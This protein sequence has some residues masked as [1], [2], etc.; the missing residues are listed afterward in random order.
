MVSGSM[1]RSGIESTQPIC[2]YLQHGL[3]IFL[4]LKIIYPLYFTLISLV[5]LR[6]R[7]SVILLGAFFVHFKKLAIPLK[8]FYCILL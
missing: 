1:E 8:V 7:C 3:E 5:P 4:I 2:Y 6:F